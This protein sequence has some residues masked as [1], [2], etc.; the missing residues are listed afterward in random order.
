VLRRFGRVLLVVASVQVGLLVT[1]CGSKS[2]TCQSTPSDCGS[3]QV[4]CTSDGKDCY[5][6]VK[7]NKYTCANGA[8]DCSTAEQQ[9]ALALCAGAPGALQSSTQDTATALKQATQ[10]LSEKAKGTRCPVCP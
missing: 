1:G 9:A 3:F 5:I 4:C 10:R 8:D 2:Y 7:G 6:T